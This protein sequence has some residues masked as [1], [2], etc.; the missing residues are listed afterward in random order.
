M[1]ERVLLGPGLQEMVRRSL[2]AFK[3]PT[4]RSA[5][6]F[7]VCRSHGYLAGEHFTC[8][9]CAAAPPH[10]EPPGLRGCGRVMGY[11][12]PVSPSTSARRAST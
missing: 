8:D 9:K 10:A 2:T 6:T 5:P 12:H 7:S 4:S 11:F 3:V 1:G